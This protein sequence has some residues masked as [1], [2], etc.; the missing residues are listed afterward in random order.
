[1]KETVGTIYELYIPG[2]PSI[3]YEYYVENK[4]YTGGWMYQDIPVGWKFKV[5]YDSINPEWHRLL[6]EQPIFEDWEEV[7]STY[8]RILK[9]RMNFTA[10][11][12]L[13]IQDAYFFARG[14]WRINIFTHRYLNTQGYTED[15][16]LNNYFKV[17]YWVQDPSRCIIVLDEPI[18]VASGM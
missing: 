3:R 6:L 18:D 16:L 7:D 12:I 4:R 15:E 2:G 10:K 17:I 11:E 1:M 14:G 5:L 8:I 9:V 13:L